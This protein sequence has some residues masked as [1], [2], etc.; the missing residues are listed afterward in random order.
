MARRKLIPRDP[1]LLEVCV[2]IGTGGITFG[3]IHDKREQANV[4]GMIEGTRSITINPAPD[5]VDSCLHECIHRMRPS[6]SERAVKARTTRIMRQLSTQEI[7]RLYDLILSTAKT[8]KNAVIY[9]AD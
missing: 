8:R 7:D 3:P 5:V 1:L 9:D 2:S 6:W 4:H